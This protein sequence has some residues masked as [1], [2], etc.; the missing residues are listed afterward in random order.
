MGEDGV[1]SL[2]RGFEPLGGKGLGL[3]Q[4]PGSATLA[5][6]YLW[7]FYIPFYFFICFQKVRV[8][9]A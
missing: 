3:L 8:G 6:H 1:H 7:H 5:C 2:R 4:L 9:L